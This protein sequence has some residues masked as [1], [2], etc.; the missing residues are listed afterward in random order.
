[1]SND[2]NYF[3][4]ITNDTDDTHTIQAFDEIGHASD[5]FGRAARQMR[6]D[7]VAGSVKMYVQKTDGEMTRLDKV[8]FIALKG[9]GIPLEV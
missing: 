9:G 4:A 7:K 1:M 5:R 2:F 6:R 3:V 8:E